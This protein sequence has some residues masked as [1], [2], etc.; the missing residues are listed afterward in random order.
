[1]MLFLQW[2]AAIVDM[3]AAFMFAH[4]VKLIRPAR[5]LCLLGNVVW[6]AYGIA[7]GQFG[8][9]ALNVVYFACVS[10]ALYNYKKNFDAQLEEIKKP[11]EEQNETRW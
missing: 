11:T 10:Y 6:V 4:D 2:F 1:M 5:Y 3:I 8:I 9:V 7:T